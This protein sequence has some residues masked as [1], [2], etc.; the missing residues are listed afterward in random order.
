VAGRLFSAHGI[1]G[2]TLSDIADE[3]DVSRGNLYSHFGSKQ[4]LVHAVCT[5][6]LTHATEQYQ[7]LSKLPPAQAIESVI[8]THVTIWK[9]FPGALSVAHELQDTSMGEAA[10]AAHSQDAVGIFERAANENLLRV[11]PELAIKMLDVIAVPLL[12]LCQEAPNPD[13][14]FVESMLRLL[15]RS[16]C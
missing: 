13:E 3:A 1:D 7:T 5:P 4:E 11:A 14:L 16:N 9:E 6:M 15:L 8:R 10:H 2:V 12:K